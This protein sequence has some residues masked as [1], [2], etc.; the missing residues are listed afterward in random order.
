MIEA[1]IYGLIYICL[2]ALAVYLIF[3]VV[4]TVLEIPI[5]DK[6]KKIVWIIV[7][8]IAVLIILNVLA[9]GPVKIWR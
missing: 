3:L 6:I 5:P 9:G 1:V 7:L 2:I 4:E 8:L